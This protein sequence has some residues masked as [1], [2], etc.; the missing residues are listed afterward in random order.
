MSFH[1]G[2]HWFALCDYFNCEDGRRC[3]AFVLPVDCSDPTRASMVL[4]A[5]GEVFAAAK[6]AG[7]QITY[8]GQEDT[9]L[10]PSHRADGGASRPEG[11]EDVPL[12]DLVGEG[13]SA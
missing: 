6:A 3:E 4:V 7:W 9:V 13:A 10:C 2:Q 5:R 11:F 1:R 8:D 12:F